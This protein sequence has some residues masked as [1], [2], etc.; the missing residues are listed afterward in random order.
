M[1]LFGG[2]QVKTNMEEFSAECRGV[3]RPFPSS[4]VPLFQNESKCET[5][6]MKMS[7]ECRFI[8]HANQSHFHKNGFALRLALKQRHKGARKW[9][10]LVV[11]A[12]ISDFFLS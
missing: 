12:N 3:D 8:F 2:T 4:L 11:T 6:H 5:F 1:G 9:P 7:S 10:I